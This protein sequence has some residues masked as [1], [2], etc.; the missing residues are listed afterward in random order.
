MTYHTVA[1]KTPNI[2]F[3][4]GARLA[5]VPEEIWSSLGIDRWAIDTAHGKNR[6]EWLSPPTPLR[7]NPQFS[8]ERGMS[9][10]QKALVDT[11]VAEFHD[12]AAIYPAHEGEPLFLS[13]IFTIPQIDKNRACLDARSLNEFVKRLHF[14]MEGIQTLRHMVRPG[15]HLVKIDIKDAYLHI[16]LH[17]ADQQLLAFQWR[18]I[19]WKFR[20]MPFG[21]SSAPRIWT[22]MMAAVMAPL[23][24]RGIRLTYYIDDICLLAATRDE[25]LRHGQIVRNH[26]ETL[27]FLLHP[28]K[29]IW[30]PMQQQTFLGFLVD[31]V[32]MEL[33]LPLDKVHKIRRE[34]KS[35]LQRTAAIPI[36][37]VASL[38]G[39]CNSTTQAVFPAR[40]RVW[41]LIRDIQASLNANNNDWNGLMMISPTSRE[42]LRWWS[43]ELTDW[44]GRSLLAER[45]EITIDTDASDLGWG[46]AITASPTIPAT[47]QAS[48]TWTPAEQGLSI[49]YREL[50]T[51]YFA[52]RINE[53]HWAGRTILV[54]TDNMT[55]R[56]FVN[57]Q[58]GSL[59]HLNEIAAAI[60]KICMTRKIRLFAE[61]LPGIENTRA[62]FLSRIRPS[63]DEWQLNP[64]MFRHLLRWGPIH[65][66]LF[67]SRTTTQTPLFYSWKADPD[68]LGTD[69]FQ[70][71]WPTSGAYANP[72]WILLNRVLR[73]VKE[74]RCARLILIT[75]FWNR[76]SWWPELLGMA[77]AP[78]ILIPHQT[79]T[80][81]TTTRTTQWDALAWRISGDPQTPLRW[82]RRLAGSFG[83]A[84]GHPL[85]GI[86]SP[87][88]NTMSVGAVDGISIPYVPLPSNART[89]WPTF[90]GRE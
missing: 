87:P 64:T 62:D 1:P 69:A 5:L 51:V 65:L 18:N 31:T 43:L 20:A 27:G 58:G 11:A 3:K 19:N 38:V 59:H 60:H 13:N 26:L 23:R 49:N 74:D 55:T 35:L 24:A 50:K 17:P 84:S 85:A 83:P 70:H 4:V 63:P 57:K 2:I 45:P 48:G 10:M 54:R 56:A 82:R 67:A 66:D 80:T 77:T 78:P 30:K 12:K 73:K 7:T 68:A 25:A 8:Y 36:R 37:K 16:P 15:D 39:L 53:R 72:P 86:T 71:P 47:P 46:F 6:I 42:D 32:K 52:L 79:L 76:Q 9:T 40:F 41:S 33:R 75:P 14:K 29:C 22:K 21:L 88:S 89:A 28:T 34:T 61:Y 44:N 90:F 81:G